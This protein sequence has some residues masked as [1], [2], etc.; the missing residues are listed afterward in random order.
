M[1]PRR[2]LP[3]G[4][5]SST[6]R[7]SRS[8]KPSSPGPIP[9]AWPIAGHPSQCGRSPARAAHGLALGLLLVWIAPSAFGQPLSRPVTS[10]PATTAATLVVR[11]APTSQRVQGVAAEPLG[12]RPLLERAEDLKAKGNWGECLDVLRKMINDGSPA[13]AVPTLES[14]IHDPRADPGARNW[15]RVL[16]LNAYTHSGRPGRAVDL[17]QAVPDDHAAGPV[18]AGAARAERGREDRP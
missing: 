3:V 10:R 16:L 12:A 2:P 13:A 5:E 14:V 17:S 11:A 8:A 6:G 9:S 18:S 7:A 4:S 15:A 1:A